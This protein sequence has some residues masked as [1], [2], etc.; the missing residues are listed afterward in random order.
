MRRVGSDQPSPTACRTLLRGSRE[1][2][3][4]HDH[5]PDAQ[6]VLAVVV[7]DQGEH[8]RNHIREALLRECLAIRVRMRFTNHDALYALS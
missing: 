6:H 2:L 8:P 5:L 3:R 1:G 4:M 7:A